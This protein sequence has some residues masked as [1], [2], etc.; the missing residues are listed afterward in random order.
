MTRPDN[1]CRIT[2]L[3]HACVLIELDG[4]RLL[5]DPV[6]RRR[7]GPLVRIAPPAELPPDIDV[8]LISHLHA[9]HLDLPALRQLTGATIVAPA[10]SGRWLARQGVPGARELLPAQSTSLGG[11][12]IR[13]TPALHDDRRFPL[14]FR[15]PPL[16]YLVEG[17]RAVYFAGDTDLFDEMAELRGAVSVGLL[18]VSGWGPRVPA[19]HL[20]PDR[21]A[22]ATAIIRPDI[23]IPMHWGTYGLIWASPPADVA[24]P[25]RRFAELARRVAP[26]VKVRVLAPGATSV[27]AG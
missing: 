7:V 23:V 6:V 19:G 2:W 3:G 21:A 26:D 24:E 27:L 22:Q 9:D 16:G 18:P 14:G 15:A 12:T 1:D 11:L 5:T 17:S 10:G 25:A 8:V 20:D 13:A 4:V